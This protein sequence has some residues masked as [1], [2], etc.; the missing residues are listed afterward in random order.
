MP[1]QEKS[2]NTKRPSPVN[3]EGRSW[4]DYLPELKEY[5]TQF[6]AWLASL[7]PRIKPLNDEQLTKMQL[8]V[9]N[10]MGLLS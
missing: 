2:P 6:D 3:I 7:P 1:K 4:F 8:H 10:Q 9:E 5:R